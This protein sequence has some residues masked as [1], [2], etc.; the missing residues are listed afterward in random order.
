MRPTSFADAR[1]ER[2]IALIVVLLLMAV[3]SGL[4]MG[5]AM[6]GQ[7]EATM[8]NNEVY[9]AGARAAAEAGINRATA[10]LRVIP[11]T[12]DVLAGEDGVVDTVN[13]AAADNAD[14]GDLGFRLSGASPY[15]LDA[16]GQ[17]SYNIEIFDDDDPALYDG[18]NLTDA[19]LTAMG[20]EG[21][22]AVGAK[23]PDRFTDRNARLILRAT[24]F[25]PSNTTVRVAR[26][27][28]TTI[29]P[30]PGSTVNPAILV[31]G[32]LIID[33]NISLLG[34][35]GNVHANGD[36]TITGN[37]ASV[38]GDA[39]ASGEFYANDNFEAGGNQGG[40]YASVNVPAVT[41]SDFLDIA[42]YIL[43]D[44]G[45]A[46]LANGNPCGAPCSDW[47]FE[48]GRWTI[49]GN[50]AS[51]GTFYSEVSIEI[52][53]SPSLKGNQPLEMTLISEGSIKITGSPVLTPDTTNNPERIMFVTD[54]DLFIGGNLDADI[55]N[56]QVEGQIF[57][58]EQIHMHG[59]P[60]FQ[61]R[62]IVQN[63]SDEFDDVTENSIGGTP[64]VTYEGTL[65]GYEIPPTTKFTYNV[66]GWIEQ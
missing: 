1:S 16:T 22:G 46:T 17:Y 40:G 21:E 50:S 10:A 52:S 53:G 60:E 39:T 41:A 4:G 44:D 35:E 27:L 57:V 3:L 34:A 7:V 61:G 65:P 54:G 49:G 64:D 43:H 62:I 66:I 33:G 15:P 32:D 48:D 42:D 58:K 5:F 24:G 63:D 11:D 51:A 38:S 13:L 19:Q 55:P 12:F 59:N 47:D 14:N 37:S 45:T 20:N 25:G 18:A 23:V 30:I 9:Y 6:N 29:I 26:V 8:A 36:L 31:D 56:P 2:G 28:L